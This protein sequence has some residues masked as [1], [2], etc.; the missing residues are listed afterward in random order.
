MA[1]KKDILGPA[2]LLLKPRQ[3]AFVVY[4]VEHPACVVSEAMGKVGYGGGNT[5]NLKVAGGAML[6][7]KKILDAIQEETGKRYRVGGLVGVH[8]MIE[9]ASNPKHPDRLKA[10]IALADRGGFGVVHESKVVHERVD[11][12]GKALMERVRELAEKLGRDP[13]DYLGP[14]V[15]DVTPKLIEK[16]KGDA[17]RVIDAAVARISGIQAT[18]QEGTGGGGSAA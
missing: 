3:Q 17:Q 15:I 4:Y 14:N 13:Q 6:R 8:G 5:K 18:G 16:E 1:V 9:I 11:L 7:N 12:T 2:M 10:C